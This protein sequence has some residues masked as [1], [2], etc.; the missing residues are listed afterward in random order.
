[1]SVPTLIV[2]GIVE[3][4]IAVTKINIFSALI[5][6]IVSAAISFLQLNCLFLL[7]IKGA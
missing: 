6:I 7:L 1:M 3:L 5:G 4:C 2:M